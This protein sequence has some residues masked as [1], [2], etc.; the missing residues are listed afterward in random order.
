[1]LR[2]ILSIAAFL[3]VFSVSAQLSFGP[4][5]LISNESGAVTVY[6]AD[7]NND[8][9]PD[10]LSTS[11]QDGIRWWQNDGAGNFTLGQYLQQT[12]TVPLSL[13]AAIADYDGDG[14]QDVVAIINTEVATSPTS[15]QYFV[16]DG[17]GGFSTGQIIGF[18]GP[19]AQEVQPADL[20]SDGDIDVV[21][22]DQADDEL[23]W[24]PNNGDGTWGSEILINTAL[25]GAQSVA[26]ADFDGDGDV[27]I[28]GSGEFD[29]EWKWFTNGG[30]EN[31]SAPILIG[32]GNNPSRSP[33]A[34]L[35][36][37][38]DQDGVSVYGIDGDVIWA[39][40][41]GSGFET[42]QFL[43]DG[44]GFPTNFP[45]TVEVVDVD[46]DGDLDVVHCSILDNTI[47]WFENLGGGSFA[48]I[49]QLIGGA[50]NVR[51]TA[52]AD[53]DGDGDLDM[54]SAN[55]GAN[56]IVWYE[57]TSAPLIFGCVD[58]NACN[59]DP[60]A[61]ADD[62]S[63]DYSC[64]GC[65]DAT[66]CNFDPA[67]TIDD[68][69][70]Q[71]IEASTLT[72]T[73]PTEFCTGDLDADIFNPTVSSVTND[74]DNQGFVIVNSSGT[75]FLQ[76]F[77]FSIDLETLPSGTFSF[78][79]VNYF[80]S[81]SG[82][83]E[84]QPF[85]NISGCF[86]ASD[87][88]EITITSGG[89]T[90]PNACNFDPIATCSL[91]LCDYSCLGCTDPAACNFDPLATVDDG[92]CDLTSCAG[93]T[94]PA[95]CNFDATA[96]IDDGSCQLCDCLGCTD[97]LA[98][99]FNPDAL[100]DDGSC[101]TAPT[102]YECDGSCTDADNDGICDVLSDSG[103]TDELALNFNPS[104]T[105]DDGSCIFGQ[106][107]CGSGTVWDPMLEQCVSTATCAGDIDEDGLINTND[108]LLFLGSFGNTCE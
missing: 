86:A 96:T 65:T 103:C 27:D 92:S 78:Y 62:G 59:F 88:I 84:G 97:P 43:L 71:L 51:Q 36:G 104:A 11:T 87:P 50:N 15:I 72:W 24:I 93:C 14:D 108:L 5:Q 19:S 45:V 28:M 30:N 21:Y 8:N 76:L 10:L 75:I 66:A 63:C 6:T 56:E 91:D 16:N 3:L 38:G 47:N 13:A 48:A 40:N 54:A 101:Y 85:A 26:C 18:T 68:G 20:D 105:I 9:I 39:E 82:I 83:S 4:A 17:S 44:P 2:S 74:G 58:P 60:A 106:D 12:G 29:D 64:L 49:E 55:F 100:E 95:A 34:T 42:P 98:C 52:F 79:V 23:G 25:D 107:L 1:M 102:G 7:F 70:C 33:M 99:N 35:D 67:A 73:G 77:N 53:F 89:C 81:A 61:T 90:D 37:D 57:N 41:N 80:N 32:S 46:Q 94:D 31:F 22:V 69:S